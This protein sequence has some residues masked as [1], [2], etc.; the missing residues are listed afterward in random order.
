M[1][2]L[3]NYFFT[4]EEFY[5]IYNNNNFRIRD[6]IVK[7]F[8]D[9]TTT[10]KPEDNIVTYKK[11]LIYHYFN[12]N[13]EKYKE[14][15]NLPKLHKN[16]FKNIINNITKYIIKIE[17]IYFY[18][19]GIFSKHTKKI[20]KVMSVDI[21]NLNEYNILYYYLSDSELKQMRF[22]TMILDK[23][24][25]IFMKYLDYATETLI[26]FELQ[27]QILD[28]VMETDF[29]T[30][31]IINEEDIPYY[32][33][34]NVL[35]LL[36]IEK[37][38]DDY[39]ENRAYIHK[40]L[41]AF[42]IL[43]CG[44]IFK[45]NYVDLI[46]SFKDVLLDLYKINTNEKFVNYFNSKTEMYK[47]KN[48]NINGFLDPTC[49]EKILKIIDLCNSMKLASKECNK[50]LIIILHYLMIG[51]F[52]NIIIDRIESN[53]IVYEY[54]YDIEEFIFNVK[55]K[56]LR[57]I[58]QE[59]P[60]HLYYYEYTVNNLD[61]PL[62]NTINF[63]NIKND[64][65]INDLEFI[66]DFITK[67][68]KNTTDYN[69]KMSTYRSV[70]KI[71]KCDSERITPSGLDINFTLCGSLQC[72]PIEYKDQLKEVFDNNT[73]NDDSL[74]NISPAYYFIG[75]YVNLSFENFEKFQ[76]FIGTNGNIGG[77]NKKYVL[78]KKV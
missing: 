16:T 74:N 32:D 56:R 15:P 68:F 28:I 6:F 18:V 8:N 45:S 4:E 55:I 48:Q 72:K 12:S 73:M 47:I 36:N 17:N 23:R 35:K 3:N 65:Q 7:K 75:H 5:N 33:N 77:K 61:N 1:E 54:I 62:E 38:Q 40:L 66:N 14:S 70:L 34:P 46:E 58:I 59:I 9:N 50:N 2:I 10:L 19:V 64:S 78:K 24:Q 22:A 21:D 69:L 49:R 30:H 57:I 44:N 13:P 63:E 39:I 52:L 37:N 11:I 76:I 42:S 51:Y 71:I 26:N 67:K 31:N 29:L 20:I 53:E 60:M 41:Y 25:L 27:K 43:K